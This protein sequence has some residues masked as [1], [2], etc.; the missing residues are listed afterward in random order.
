MDNRQG[1]TLSFYTCDEGSNDFQSGNAADCS[2]SFQRC[3]KQ[4]YKYWQEYVATEP[5]Y[6]E[7]NCTYEMLSPTRVKIWLP[8][9]DFVKLQ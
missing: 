6:F 5:Q 3:L 7:S 1:V 9:L 2:G 8:V 4:H